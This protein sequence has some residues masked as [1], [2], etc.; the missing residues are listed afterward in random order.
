[1]NRTTSRGASLRWP[2][3]SSSLKS[4]VLWC[5]TFGE[6]VV[7]CNDTRSSSQSQ[8]GTVG[9]TDTDPRS[10]Q[11]MTRARDCRSPD[12]RT[13]RYCRRAGELPG[14]GPSATGDRMWSHLDTGDCMRS[15]PFVPVDFEPPRS[16]VT[17]Q[18]VLYPVGPQHKKADHDAWTS[19]IEHIR[20][21]PG[22]P[23]GDWP[24]INGMSLAG[25]ESCRP[26]SPRDRFRL[27]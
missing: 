2:S 14:S 17:D 9:R 23:D 18:F 26:D 1:M 4:P 24:P 6:V 19:S 12:F 27:S 25:G 20:A 11:L 13:I 5:R 22:Y 3:R 7:D 15:D 21:T 8:E 10:S 16:L